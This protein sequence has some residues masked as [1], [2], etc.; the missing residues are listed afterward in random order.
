[1]NVSIIDPFA[2]NRW[3]ELV[4]R[5]PKASVFHEPGW[6]Q[7]LVQT[8]GYRPLVLTSTRRGLPLVDG[9]IFCRVSS[10]V[11]GTRLVSLPFADHCEP[12]LCDG[13]QGETIR[14]FANWLEGECDR[15]KLKYIE[16]RTKSETDDA[17]RLH[18]GQSY[19]LHTL[20][21]TRPLRQIFE[22]LH[23]DC[24][25]RRIRRAERACLS[26]ETGDNDQLLNEFYS[27]WTM[28]RRRHRLVPQPRNWF[29]N[30]IRCMSKKVQIRLAR[31]E[32]VAIAAILT[33]VHRSS[34]VYKY[35]CSEARYH[36]LGGMP[37][38]FWKLIEESKAAGA[39]EIDFGRSDLDNQGLIT[40]KDRFGTRKK[41]I[42]YIRYPEA[43]TLGATS[44]WTVQAIRDLF[45]I[46]PDA[47][48]PTVGRVLYRHIG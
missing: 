26:Y 16:L 19:Y 33:L 15:K 30:L 18:S 27:L 36:N 42:T 45:S 32:G 14:T 1:L 29:R 17:D 13:G 21:L 38:L 46:M 10:W 44:R 12:L 28:T 4:A 47:L 20:D 2:D 23:R 6:I 41:L 11:T 34:V 48:L 35:G 7:A 24:V 39:Q 9:L 37:F 8:Y 5:H 43:G 40:F 31:R 22:A 3:A 25:Q